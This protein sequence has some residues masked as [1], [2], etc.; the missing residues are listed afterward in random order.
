MLLKEALTAV[1]KVFD[2]QV[3]YKK[4]GVIV[5]GL[6]PKAYETG[7][8]FLQEERGAEKGALDAVV[9]ALNARFGHRVVQ[10]AVVKRNGT[11]S[12]SLLRSKEYTTLWKDIPTV[13]AK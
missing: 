2:P 1:K 12:A 9:D 13:L 7:D 6:L 10:T 3:P 8:L 5:S 4:A 11:L